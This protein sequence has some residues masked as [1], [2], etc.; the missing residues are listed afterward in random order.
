[1]NDSG[2]LDVPV[3]CGSAS[4][5]IGM[6][7]PGKCRSATLSLEQDTHAQTPNNASH[8][9]QFGRSQ[10]R[11]IRSGTRDDTLGRGPVVLCPA[12]STT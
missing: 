6:I 1:M 11:R 7:Y 12:R 9:E 10:A 2:R 5:G 8:A 3:S 4:T